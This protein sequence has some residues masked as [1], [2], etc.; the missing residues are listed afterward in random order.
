[1]FMNG[2]CWGELLSVTLRHNER[3]KTLPYMGIPASP[4]FLSLC[5]M[6]LHYMMPIYGDHPPP[7]GNEVTFE[8]ANILWEN[9][10]VSR[11]E[12]RGAKNAIGPVPQWGAAAFVAGSGHILGSFPSYFIHNGLRRT[13]ILESSS[14]NIWKIFCSSK[15]PRS[16][17]GKSATA[18]IKETLS[19][20]ISSRWFC[21]WS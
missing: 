20:F 21:K 11:E 7:V 10:R 12:K 15:R 16:L 8:R 3:G 1:M 9:G 14:A 18:E 4:T 19:S 2:F 6:A 13:E 5:S 17:L